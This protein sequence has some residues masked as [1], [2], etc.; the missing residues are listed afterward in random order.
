MY[1]DRIIIPDELREEILNRLHG[2][3]QGIVKTRALAKDSVWWPGLS[4][5]IKTKVEDCPTCVKERQPA[6]EPLDTTPVPDR[7]WKKLGSDIMEWEGEDYLLV[8]DYFSKYIELAL[9]KNL[10]SETTV[11]HMK[12][13][14]VQG[15]PQKRRKRGV[16]SVLAN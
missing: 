13:A 15:E 2:G 9:L 5:Q 11:G 7:P 3:H 4:T 14:W 16:G 6:H 8:V 10:T 12:S 1:R